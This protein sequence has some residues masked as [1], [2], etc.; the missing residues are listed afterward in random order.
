MCAAAEVAGPRQLDQKIS[1]I[2]HADDA[3]DEQM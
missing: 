3:D 2:Q 1:E